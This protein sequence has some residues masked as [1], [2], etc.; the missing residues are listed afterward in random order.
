M[1]IIRVVWVLLSVSSTLNPDHEQRECEVATQGIYAKLESCC[2]I[3]PH[4]LFG[5]GKCKATVQ[6]YSNSAKGWMGR[7]ATVI[8]LCAQVRDVAEECVWGALLQIS[9]LTRLQDLRLKVREIDAEGIT[10][11]QTLKDL[12]SLDLE[13]RSILSLGV[14]PFMTD[15]HI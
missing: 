8:R 6:E 15:L 7:S 1:P 5:W 14:D 4:T 13:V 3:A 11:L 2:H 9:T 10:A 12:R